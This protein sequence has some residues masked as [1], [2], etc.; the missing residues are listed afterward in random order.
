MDTEADL[1]IQLSFVNADI[2]DFPGG[3]DGKS[4]CLHRGRPRFDPWVG[5]IPWRRNWQPT[6]VLLPGKSHGWRNLVGYN[7]WGHKE[8]DTTEQLHFKEI[9]SISLLTELF[10]FEN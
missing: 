4:I 10:F 7:P 1:R 9:Y 5:K 3:S 8:L 6:R 2:K